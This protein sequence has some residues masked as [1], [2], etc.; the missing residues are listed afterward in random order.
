M[1]NRPYIL[2]PK[3]IQQPT[4]GGTYIAGMKGW[5]N[6]P[7]MQ[8][9]KIGQS[10]E[11]FGESKLALK[12]TDTADPKFIPELGFADKPDILTDLF[13]YQHGSD[14]VNLKDV[15]AKEKMPILIKM[16][17][18]KGNSF[19]LHLK[20]GE[21]DERWR[22]KAESWYYLE[23]GYLTFGI[24]DGIDIG[25]YKKTCLEIEKFMKEISGEIV[26][27]KIT[28]EE[29][30]ARASEYI[31]A[32]DPHKFVNLYESKK[33]EVI[34][35][36][37]GGIHH[38][39]E[40]DELKFP[41]GNIVYEIQ[42]D[43]MDPVC[44][45]RSFDQGKIKDDGTIREID[46][47]SYFKYLDTDPEHNIPKSSGL[48]YEGETVIDTQRYKMDVIELSDVRMLATGNSFNHIFVRNGAVEIN[49]G[50]YNLK[51]GTGFSAFVP[52]E[53]ENYEIK[54]IEPG[55][56]VLKTYI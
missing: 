30:R 56:V 49:S 46:I 44:T 3:L 14:Y 5:S 2:I 28:V 52:Q 16:T 55:T 29:G 54:P 45:I 42:E 6:M 18:S 31:K 51:L 1:N 24:K 37:L 11:L 13:D 39:W 40:E 38:S 32:N 50:I 17:E 35:P 7:I 41:L 53:A 9:K 34:D 19:Q 20:H 33:Y 47:E 8:G 26:S 36:S 23:P 22:P 12:I 15:I 10:Y 48:E 43:V 25:E 21:A 27:G 4:W